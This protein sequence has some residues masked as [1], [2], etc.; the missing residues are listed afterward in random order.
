MLYVSKHI[1]FE[2]K[3]EGKLQEYRRGISDSNLKLSK[4]TRNIYYF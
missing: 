4:D 3:Y 2:F 1:L